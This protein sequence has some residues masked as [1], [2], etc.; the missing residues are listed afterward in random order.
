MANSSTDRILTEYDHDVELYTAFT[1]KVKELVNEVLRHAGVEAHAVT[2]RVKSRDSLH[3]KLIDPDKSY[4]ALVDLTDIA[5]VRVITYFVDDVDRVAECLERE[6]FVDRENSI[7]RRATLDPDQFGYLSLHHIVSFGASRIELLEYSRYHGLKAEIQTRSILQHA[8]AEI[9]HDLGYQTREAVPKEIRRRFSALAGMLEIADREF[10]SLR[11]ELREYER[12][13]PE[14]IEKDPQSVEI[15]KASLS[16]FVENSPLVKRADEAIASSIGATVLEWSEHRTDAWERLYS[17]FLE[18]MVAGLRALRVGTIRSLETQLLQHESGI[19]NFVREYL[20]S[21][22][23]NEEGRFIFRGESIT[24]LTR[25]LAGKSQ[26]LEETRR[27]LRAR[28]QP[29]TEASKLD[30]EAHRLFGAYGSTY[31]DGNDPAEPA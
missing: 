5:G 23:W 3:R 19:V 1:R 14:K 10:Q 2:S 12:G 13:V 4:S 21:E 28:G 16:A 29:Y 25:L 15:D 27:F 31:S 6:F 7:D 20:K 11:D 8:W 30:E 24:Y 26:N 17:A 22:E 18:R 9:E